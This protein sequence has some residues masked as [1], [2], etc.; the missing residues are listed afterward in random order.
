LRV[1]ELLAQRVELAFTQLRY[2]GGA[3]GLLSKLGPSAP[4]R[5]RI[6][7]PHRGWSLDRHLLPGPTIKIDQRRLARNQPPAG[8]CDRGGD[9]VGS[10]DGDQFAVRLHGDDGAHVRV[11][12]AELCRVMRLLDR[13][14]LGQAELRAG[15]DQPRIDRQPCRVNHLGISRRGDPRADLGDLAVAN[16]H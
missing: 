1:F 10:R 15:I 5:A 12:I 13:A 7:H 16:Q 3:F 11:E 2:V 6:L 9:A 14:D 4:R 8:V